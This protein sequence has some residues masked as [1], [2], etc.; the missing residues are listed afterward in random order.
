MPL[1]DVH[2]KL[3][4]RRSHRRHRRRLVNLITTAYKLLNDL[5]FSPTAH[6]MYEL[7]SLNDD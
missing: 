6:D 2:H 1:F 5:K 4:R 7:I 3:D